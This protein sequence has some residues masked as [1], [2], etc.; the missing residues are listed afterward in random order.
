MVVSGKQKSGEVQETNVE[1]VRFGATDGID[2]VK[3][4]LVVVVFLRGLAGC[5]RGRGLGIF[6]PTFATLPNCPPKVVET[7]ESTMRLAT[8]RPFAVL[9]PVRPHTFVSLRQRSTVPNASATESLSPRWLADVKRRLGKCV[10]FGLKPEQTARAG[11]ILETVAR[12]WRELVVGSEGFLTSE[13]RRG[14]YRHAV[15]WGEMDSM[16]GCF[17]V[18][19][20]RLD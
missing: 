16:V 6:V 1:K 9:Q 13:D 20:R 2:N 17:C 12:D 8:P 4:T 19:S 14:F 11:A 15:V 7:V 3:M 10:T 18:L 5:E